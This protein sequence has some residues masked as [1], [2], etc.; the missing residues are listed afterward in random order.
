MKSKGRGRAP[1]PDFGKSQKFSDKLLTKGYLIWYSSFCPVEQ[2]YLAALPDADELLRKYSAEGMRAKELTRRVADEL[3][4]PRREI[5][6][7]YLK[8]K[9][10]F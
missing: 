3:K 5:Y 4:Q 7:L 9:D 8:I 1:L 10:T 6:D 2:E